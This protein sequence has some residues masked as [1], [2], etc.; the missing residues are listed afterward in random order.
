MQ[1][2]DGA[3]CTVHVSAVGHVLGTCVLAVWVMCCAK[4]MS[5]GFATTTQQVSGRMLVHAGSSVGSR[6]GGL[7]PY[8]GVN[9]STSIGV[10]S[11]G[12][13]HMRVL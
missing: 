13:H 12:V 10:A 9:I 7:W 1:Y 4:H 8:L 3:V 11:S 6:V 2:L 5:I